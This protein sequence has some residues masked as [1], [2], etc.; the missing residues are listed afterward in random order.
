[1]PAQG[2]FN[3]VASKSPVSGGITSVLGYNPNLGDDVYVYNGS[4]YNIFSY[5][6]HGSGHPVVYTTNWFNGATAGEPI[7]NVGQGFWLKPGAPNTW[8]ET[9]NP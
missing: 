3:L 8:T 1:V 4:G 2:T 6:S 9:V 5:I 7:I